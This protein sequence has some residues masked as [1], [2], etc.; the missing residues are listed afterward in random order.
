MTAPAEMVGAAG[1]EAR[2]GAGRG[3]SPVSGMASQTDEPAESFAE[4][5]TPGWRI[6]GALNRLQK[7]PAPAKPCASPA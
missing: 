1:S 6:K 5:P 7:P 2:T 4:S 3:T